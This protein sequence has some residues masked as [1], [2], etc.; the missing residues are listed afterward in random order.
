MSTT[1]E[2]FA[3]ISCPFTHVGL[4][5]VTARLQEMEGDHDIVVRAWPLEW[6]NGAALDATTTAA[7]VAALR[8]QLDIELFTGFRSDRWPDTTIP[9]LNLAAA[10]YARDPLTGLQVSLGLRNALFEQGQDISDPA[11]LAALAR[12]FDLAR[13]ASEPTGAVVAD[14]RE[15]LR[16]G[17]TGSPHFW[18]GVQEFFCP[19]LDLGHDETGALTA[20]L[21]LDGLADF[22]AGLSPDSMR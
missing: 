18:I 19:S 11:V 13:P 20:A 21:D 6:V 22:L 8:E 12:T 3:D 7:K 4:T 1:V 16:R 15:G 5:P 9:A 14:H 10:A 17:V 2:V